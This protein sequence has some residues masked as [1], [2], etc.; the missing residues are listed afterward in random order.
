MT[1][2]LSCKTQSRVADKGKAPQGRCGRFPR[3]ALPSPP[4]T[5]AV[6]NRPYIKQM[7]LLLLTIGLL[8]ATQAFAQ[9]NLPRDP[10]SKDGLFTICAY[11]KF[12]QCDL[13]SEQSLQ[14]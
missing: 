9:S 10:T 5:S 2:P 14:K 8:F 12:D 4:A 6:P 1:A 3:E 11:Q 13:L 7:R